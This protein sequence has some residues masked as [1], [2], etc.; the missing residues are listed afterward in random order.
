MGIQYS[1]PPES[2]FQRAKRIHLILRQELREE[3]VRHGIAKLYVFK[4]SS[5]NHLPS[6]ETPTK[7]SILSRISLI[8]YPLGLLDLVT[9]LAKSIMQDLWRFKFDWDES[10]P[11][12]LHTKWKRFET[13]LQELHGIRIPR[14][15]TTT[16]QYISLELHG[17]S[18]ASEIAYGA[19]IYL[20]STSIDG[21]YRTHLL[22]SK[23]RVTPLKCSSLP[24]L[25]LC[26]ALL[27]AR[28]IYKISKCLQ[29]VQ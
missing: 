23:S 18:D 13:E 28:L 2:K 11:L 16:E 14:F 25:K 26:D 27:L 6:L 8:F 29:S 1:W 3:S 12:E 7:R 15:V 17:F 4:Y 9:L 20:H 5:I 22:C 21:A 24:R 19:C 10:I